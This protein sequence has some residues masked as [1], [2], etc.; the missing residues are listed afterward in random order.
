MVPTCSSLIGLFTGYAVHL[1]S[2]PSMSLRSFSPPLGPSTPSGAETRQ[3]GWSV[4]EGLQDAGIRDE[5]GSPTSEG[6]L[7]CGDVGR[8][9]CSVQAEARAPK[10]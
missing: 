1:I 7:E 6:L 10:P 5:A 3:A 4:G 8:Q 2:K 9:A